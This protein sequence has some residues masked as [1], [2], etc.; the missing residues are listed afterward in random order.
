MLFV[1]ALG[2]KLIGVHEVV[3]AF[4]AGLAINATVPRHSPVTGHVLFMGESFFI[5]VF[6]LYS[7]MITDP[8]TIVRNPQAIY[9]ALGILFVAYFSKLCASWITSRIFHYTNAEFWTVYGLS[10]AQAAVTIPTLVIGMQVGLFSSDVFNAAILMILFTS[11][12]SPLIV[13]KFAPKLRQGIGEVE[14][15]PLFHRILVPIANPATQ[16]HLLTLA[17]L[18]AKTSHGEV[19]AANV[20]LDQ[21]DQASNM[22]QQKELL[23]RVP[24]II[25]DPE[26]RYELVPRLA[27]SYAK[28]ILQISKERESTLI[29]MGWRGKRTFKQSVLGTVLDEVI[30]GSDTPVLVGKLEHPLIGMQ[31]V[32][33]LLPAGAVSPLVL[34][35]IVQANRILS[36]ALNVPLDILAHKSYIDLLRTILGKNHKD[37]PVQISEMI[38][39]LRPDDLEKHAESDL[40]VIPGF[41]SRKRFLANLGNMPER[42]A[43]TF[44]GNLIII[45]FDR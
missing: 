17:S 12:T 15:Q 30:W 36:D 33:L 11:I 13:Q 27:N 6:L 28:G 29:I 18:L 43:E 4:L 23:N 8:L 31:R 40:L 3:G 14:D 37:N 41:G 10:H 7:G 24:E 34:R 1:A 5:P 39:S 45:H 26:T 35:R 16:E 22:H 38:N 42:L 20:V 19:V 2:A 9:I 25:N 32:L 44:K 21:D